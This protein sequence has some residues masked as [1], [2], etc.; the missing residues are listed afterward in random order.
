MSSNTSEAWL[1][2]LIHPE[3]YQHILRLLQREQY[4]REKC[5]ERYHHKR[6][7]QLALHLAVP[8][9]CTSPEKAEG[10]FMPQMIVIGV[11]GANAT[12]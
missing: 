4:N 8:E 6:K 5:R 2:V 10:P 12:K 9:L 11:N 1:H 3:E 7:A